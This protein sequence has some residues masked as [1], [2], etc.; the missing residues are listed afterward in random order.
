MESTKL[1]VHLKGI[2]PLIMHCDKLCNPMHP[3]SKRLKEISSIRGKKDEHYIAMSEIEWFGALYYDEEVGLHLTSKV[4]LGCFQAAARKFKLGKATKAIFIDCAVGVPLLGYEK[5][6]PDKLW[7][8]KNK[9]GEQT[10]VFYNTVVVGMSRV[11]RTL[12]IFQKWEL[13]FDLYLNTELLSEKQLATILN[14][15]GFEFGFCELRPENASGTYGRFT[16]ESI[17]ET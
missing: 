8:L 12:P 7:A 4:L 16:V 14:T 5:M 15:A 17:N 1:T 9:A 2:S 10:H 13:K 6:T 11:V 3:D